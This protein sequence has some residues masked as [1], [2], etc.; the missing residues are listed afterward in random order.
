MSSIK[1]KILTIY[2]F[3]IFLTFCVA[4]VSIYNLYSLNKAVDGLIASNYRSIV[5]A[6]NMLDA[7]ERQDSYEL[8]YIQV[9]NE[10]IVRSFYEN[11]REF[12]T[13]LTKAQ[14][15]ITEE[16][17]IKVTEHI[18]SNY[19]KYIEYFSKLQQIKGTSGISAANNFYNND[20]YSLFLSVKKSCSE[21]LEIN[22]IAMFNS[23]ERAT[24]KSQR[25]MYGTAGLSVLSILLGL[26]VAFTYTRKI[27][28][29]VHL[30][31]SG[32]KSLKEGNLNHEI[33][34][35][36]RDEI[37]ELASE[38]NNMTRRLHLYEKSNIRN[39]IAEKNK[40]LAIVKSISD[41]II[42][43]DNDF[44]IILVNKATEDVFKIAEQNS[45]G[46]HFLESIN[47]QTIFEHIKHLEKYN[48]SLQGD[49]VVVLKREERLRYYVITVAAIN[50]NENEAVGAVTVLQDITGLK[51]IERL[52]SEFIST[53]S[54]EIRTPLTSIVMGTGLLLDSITGALTEDQKEVVDAMHEDS[55]QL[56]ALVNDLLDLSKIESGR[57]QVKFENVS[58]H[59]LIESSIRTFTDIAED[60][61]VKLQYNEQQK[62]P[63]VKVDIS[64]ITC[65]VNN[66]ITNALKFTK[67]GDQ[68]IISTQ[69]S[70]GS[71]K[72]L[73]S[74]NGVG[75]AEEDRERIFEKFVQLNNEKVN[76]GGTG[77]GLAI[78][79]EF[80]R[81]H[82]GDIWVES[83]TSSGS[84]FIFTIPMQR[85][86]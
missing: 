16:N 69:I 60:K 38:F 39:L 12:I 25:Q 34:V 18:S 35:V 79:K 68:V 56:L 29:P 44:R 49:S 27:V 22:E 45:I 26:F 53:I 70:N 43:T 17:E 75:I 73:V 7:I 62:I 33:K 55:N 64:K 82:G 13:W 77:L 51:E 30:L 10:N 28:R 54:H 15:N 41:P 50:A 52:K 85:E 23:K 19:T 76:N 2:T 20:I 66:L 3:L 78:S 40:S 6:R 21:L 4:A 63:C 24:E 59:E 61:G 80:V 8:I 14:D 9:D 5:A 58:L 81:L 31:I 84:S 47:N 67:R 11:Q 86:V 74:D 72:V 83:N 71:I 57:S 37:G 32:I 48:K 42:V 1:T 65:V 36:S 46:R